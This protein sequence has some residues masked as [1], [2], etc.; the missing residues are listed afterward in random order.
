[1]S[2]L[3][4]GAGQ[5]DS[6]AGSDPGSQ[7]SSSGS[8]NIRPD[9]TEVCGLGELVVETWVSWLQPPWW[10]GGILTSSRYT[11]WGF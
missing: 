6:G 9:G 11:S 10:R 1:M 4:V 5:G 3:N 8:W 7:A 2:C